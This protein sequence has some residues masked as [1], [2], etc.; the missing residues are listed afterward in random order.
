MTPSRRRLVI[1]VEV[2]LLLIAVAVVIIQLQPTC[3]LERGCRDCEQKLAL[4]GRKLITRQAMGKQRR[5]SGPDFL[6]QVAPDLSDEE[7][8]CFV[9]EWDDELM[10]RIPAP[11]T[12]EFVRLYRARGGLGAPCSWAGPDWQRYPRKR[13][14]SHDGPGRIW[15]CDRLDEDLPIHPD[16]LVLY[17]TGGI[18]WIPIDRIEGADPNIGLVSLGED[19]TDPR[20]RKMRR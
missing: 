1:S 14:T 4:I 6:L 8:G 20:F 9:A 3:V 7:L 13:R 10:A 12:P 15:A 5:Y 2:A 11:G 17:E 18:D 16:I 19:A